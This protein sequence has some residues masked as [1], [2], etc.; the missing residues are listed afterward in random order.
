MK[1]ELFNHIQQQFK[2]FLKKD[3][4]RQV[5]TERVMKSRRRAEVI[6]MEETSVFG[7]DDAPIGFKKIVT[8]K[9]GKQ[10]YRIVSSK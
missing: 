7:K 9:N 1:Q 5:V 4:N 10:T 6:G 3:T 8:D 2:S